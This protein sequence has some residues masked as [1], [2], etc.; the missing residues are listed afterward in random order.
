[1]MII[2]AV[3]RAQKC[4]LATARRSDDA[5]NLSRENIE[6]DATERL[7]IAKPEREIANDNFGGHG[8]H[9]RALRKC[10]RMTMATRLSMTTKA[11]SVSAVP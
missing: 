10:A 11:T 3:Q 8:Y 6:A 4:R 2:H 1:M 7:R 9:R 5:Q